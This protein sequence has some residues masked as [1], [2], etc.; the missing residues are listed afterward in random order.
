MP[1]TSEQAKQV[2]L[3]IIATSGGR[4]AGKTRLYKA[5]YLAHL[6]YW[7][8]T[9]GTL[10]DHSI[11]RMPMGPGIDDGDLLIAE[12]E[13]EGRI[14]ISWQF[15]GPYKEQVLEIAQ[16][17]QLDPNDP[18][19]KAIEEAVKWI[20]GKTAAELSN[21]THEHSRSWREGCDGDV[22][23]IYVDLLEDCEYERVKEAVSQAD[24]LL[25]EAFR[26]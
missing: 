23:D 26:G 14:K 1:E 18:R 6:Y 20:E 8:N 16:P 2:I 24:D 3:E 5:F 10:T 9:C 7:E 11:V 4:L 21:I 15:N 25:A 13:A 19:F 22:L 12:L 17:V